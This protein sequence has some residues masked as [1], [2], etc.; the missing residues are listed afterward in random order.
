[1]FYFNVVEEVLVIR[2]GR[3]DSMF[4]N[5]ISGLITGFNL[6]ILDLTATFR[7]IQSCFLTHEIE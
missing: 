4:P 6:D 1:V 2:T 5:K 7:G 3:M